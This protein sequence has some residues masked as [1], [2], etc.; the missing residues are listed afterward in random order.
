MRRK[1]R[2]MGRE[3]GL[4][5]IDKARFGVV[6]MIDES[7]QA[8]GLP[9][10]IVREGDY[11]YLH[12]AKEGKKVDIFNSSPVVNVTFVGDVAVPDNFSEEELDEMVK[13][14][15]KTAFLISSVFT[16]QYE[17]AI[18]KGRVQPV[19]DEEERVK[20][21]RLICEK[22]TPDK[23]KYFPYA[24]KAGMDRVNVYRIDIRELTAK[25]KKYDSEGKEMKWGRM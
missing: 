17:S 2:E 7:E 10:S 11:L 19:D 21:L 20:A 4:S 24:I 9:L 3:F 25:R 23:M 15:N 16:T 18:V 12:S 8:Y 1:D 5:I 14:E 6:S 13:D 22:Y